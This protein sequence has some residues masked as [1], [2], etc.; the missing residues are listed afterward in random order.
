MKSSKFCIIVTVVL[1][2]RGG[3]S[4]NVITKEDA[5]ALGL[6]ITGCTDN[7]RV[8]SI[9]SLATIPSESCI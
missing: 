6:L 1:H 2:N 9:V 5:T 4:D 3:A 8:C 7:N